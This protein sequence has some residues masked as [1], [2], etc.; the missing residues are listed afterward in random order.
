[1]TTSTPRSLIWSA[2]QRLVGEFPTV[3]PAEIASTLIDARR[4]VDMLG[5]ALDDELATAEKLAR[6]R[7]TQRAAD[8]VPAARLEPERHIGRTTR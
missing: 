7:L 5:L 4:A 3:P 1:M 6:E 8:H 2:A